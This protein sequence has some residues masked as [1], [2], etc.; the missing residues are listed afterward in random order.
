MYAIG[1]IILAETL[2]INLAKRKRMGRAQIFVVKF[3]TCQIYLKS[4]GSTPVSY[5]SPCSHV[6]KVTCYTKFW[7][8][9]TITPHS[10]MKRAVSSRH[11]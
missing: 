4:A 9:V 1:I 11:A 7:L 5:P 2:S 6:W 10:P 8:R 3:Y